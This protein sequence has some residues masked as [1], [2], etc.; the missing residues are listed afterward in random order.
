MLLTFAVSGYRSL[1][2]LILPLDRITLITGANGSG[3]SSLYRS[4]RLLAEVAQGRAIASLATEGGLNSTLWAGPE[5]VSRAMKRGEVPVQGTVR[6]GTVAL[7]LGF[8][9]EDYGYAIDLGLPADAGRS[10][11]SMD[12]EIKCEALW[13][14][15]AL[16]R[17][18]EIAGRNGPSVRVLNQQG[19]R[20][21]VVQNLARFDSMMTHA[22]DPKDGLELLVLR[23]RMRAWRFYDHLRTDREAPARFPKIGTRT[24]AL[25]AD[26]A[27]LAAAVQTILEI[28]DEVALAEAIDDAFPGAE[29]E[30]TVNEGYFELLMRQ[31][32]LLRPLRAAELSDGTLRY[33][34]LTAALLS[35]RPAPLIVLNEP[36]TSLHPSLL[37]PLARLISKA[38]EKTQVLVVSHAEPLVNALAGERGCLHHHLHKEL[39]ETQVAD[40]EPPRWRW[41]S[42]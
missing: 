42:R 12:P 35:P 41:P 38:A 7:K 36:E 40:A 1:R 27:D 11:F 21:P 34:L 31:K 16:S 26:G 8:A 32:G 25:S 33:L 17:S 20:L 3:K 4:I 6:K 15:E 24:P 23:E 9:D 22:A 28:G 29:V 18:N 19:Q 10:Y 30:I 2:D 14:G 37:E 5:T 39:G 13:A